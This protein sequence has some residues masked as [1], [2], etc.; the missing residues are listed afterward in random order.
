MERDAKLV[1]LL[2]TEL[3]AV[4]IIVAAPR[5]V[6]VAGRLPL[7]RLTV[8]SEYEKIT[9]GW[10][11]KRGQ[12]DV[13]VRTYGATEVFPPEDADCI[14]DNTETGETLRANNLEI[15]EEIMS[16]S[17]R[18]YANPRALED[19]QKRERIET[20]VMLL[21]SVLE[22]RKRVMLDLN[23]TADKLEAVIAVLPCMKEPTINL[24][25]GEAGYAVK[26]AVMK[27]DLARVIPLIKEKGGTDIVV[28]AVS[29]IIL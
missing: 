21:R 25:H 3:A 13:F 29:Q 7:R 22:A 20:V 11:Q 15:V 6:L 28:S 18:L 10:I 5:A 16:S 1:E 12:G 14:V 2:D 17:T 19:P 26:S 24:L 8:A 4:K 23:V 9:K 27:S